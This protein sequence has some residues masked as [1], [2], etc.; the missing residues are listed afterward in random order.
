[1]TH[2]D[3]VATAVAWLRRGTPVEHSDF[4]HKHVPAFA[5]IVTYANERPDAI[6]W[7]QGLS[8]VVECK[9]SRADF[10]ADRAK[11][12]MA[13]ETSGMGRRRWYLVPAGLV[14]ASEVPAWCGLAYAMGRRVDAVKVAPLRS[15]DDASAQA[16]CL[17]LASAVRRHV[18]GVPFDEKRGRFETVREGDARRIADASR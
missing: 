8:T 9:A 11:F 6:G 16:E 7:H 5:E 2:A 3:L 14:V 10:F 18:L 15:I 13:S 4:P 12:H 1:M 17:V